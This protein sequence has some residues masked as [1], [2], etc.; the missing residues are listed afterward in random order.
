MK[1]WCVPEAEDVRLRERTKDA[2]RMRSTEPGLTASDV[3]I[4]LGISERTLHRRLASDGKTFA[5]LLLQFRIDKAKRMLDA[6]NF[7][8]VTIAEIGRRAGFADSSYFGR[9]IKRELGLAPEGYRNSMR[10]S[11]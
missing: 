4:E 6:K 10:G 1:A 5:S 2:I 8:S 7:E 11:E 9:T 3:A